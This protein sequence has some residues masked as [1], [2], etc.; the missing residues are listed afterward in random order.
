MSADHWLTARTGL[1]STAPPTVRLSTRTVLDEPSRP[2]AAEPAPEIRFTRYGLSAGA[3]L[4]DVHDHY[5]AELDHVRRV[6]D[7][8][9]RGSA[10]IGEARSAINAMAVT[11][12]D[13]TIRGVCQAQCQMVA[14]HHTMESRAIFPHLRRSQ[15]DLDPVIQRLDDEHLAIH[16][17]LEEIDAALVHLAAYPGDH[18][19]ILDAVDLLTDTL[20]SHFAYEERELIAPL[21]RHGFFPGQV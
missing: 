1:A 4:L 13:W 11:Q 16:H 7:Q 17:V 14:Q 18:Q 5:R 3:H 15:P 21:S 9:R 10:D 8:V 20:L 2:S 19:P 12:H 6:L